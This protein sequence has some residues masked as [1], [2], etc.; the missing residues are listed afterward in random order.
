MS[1]LREFLK[2]DYVKN[3]LRLFGGTSLAQ[4]VPILIS[5]LLTRLYST[6]QFGYFA[7]YVSVYTVLTVFS[8]G[9][10]DQAI[11]LSKNKR[12]Q[13]VLI[14]ICF[15]FLLIVSLS[16]EMFI[17]G[18]RP[19]I[20]GYIAWA[21]YSFLIYLIPLSTFLIGTIQLSNYVMIKEATFGRLSYIK[22]S[23]TLLVS[24]ITVLFGYLSVKTGLVYGQLLGML[25]ISLILVYLYLADTEHKV[26][27][28]LKKVKEVL[29]KYS[30]FPKYD[31]AA[32]FLSVGTPQSIVLLT[33]AFFTSGVVGLYALT[34]RVLLAPIYFISRSI[35]DVFRERAT[36]DYNDYG[37]CRGIY[38]KTFGLLIAVA[39]VPF[40]ILFL[41]GE[42][43]FSLIFG[44]EWKAAGTI[45]TVLSPMYFLKFVSSP[46]SYV[47]Y[48]AEK[49]KINLFFQLTLFSSIVVSLFVGDHYEDYLMS[50]KLIAYCYSVFYLVY[51]VLSYRWSVANQR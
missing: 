35:I 37:S 23:Q 33:G 13:N 3:I 11:I 16:F 1:S 17:V 7:T 9:R 30:N 29:L 14:T 25:T 44:P 20:A 31:I 4:I 43:L 27:T 39:I 24:G 36:R 32:N 2:S 46:L 28:D 5:P 40:T 41:F 38:K 6:E 48:I 26:V 47:L 19:H 34:N 42:D 15:V 22:I 51:L 8:T 10:Y 21:E 50:F 18:F 12:E 49:Q 45:A